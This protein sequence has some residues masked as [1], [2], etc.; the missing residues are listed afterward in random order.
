MNE[1]LKNIKYSMQHFALAPIFAACCQWMD[2]LQQLH[3]HCLHFDYFFST[4]EK[5]KTET[6]SKH[7]SAVFGQ[8]YLNCR[9]VFSSSD[10][11]KSGGQGFRKFCLRIF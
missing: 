1:D 2:G 6:L 10:K 5:R 4:A 9:F 8:C 3:R 7:F 11:M